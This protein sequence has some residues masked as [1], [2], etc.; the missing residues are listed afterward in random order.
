MI[1]HVDKNLKG[2]LVYVYYGSIVYVNNRPKNWI[3]RCQITWCLFLYNVGW[4]NPDWQCRISE[5]VVVHV[6]WLIQAR[7]YKTFLSCSTQLSMNFSL[8]INMK[9]P[10]MSTI[11]MKKKKCQQ[12]TEKF[13]CSA[14]LR[15]KE[16]AIVSDLRFINRTNFM[17]SWVEHEKRFITWDQAPWDFSTVYHRYNDSICAKR[18]YHKEYLMSRMT[19]KKGLVVFLFP[20][21]TLCF[22]Y[23]VRRFW[24]NIWNLMF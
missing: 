14:I 15:K 21:R 11:N 9:M 4:E 22:I 17:L 16:D 8:L 19:C 1:N 5:A 12:L 3:S 23:F 20:H 10:K 6:L 7:G 18:C 2:T 24:Q 13:S